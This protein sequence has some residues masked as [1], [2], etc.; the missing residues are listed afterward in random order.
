MRAKCDVC[1]ILDKDNSIKEVFFCK[2]CN[3]NI[4]RECEP[5]W[6]RRGMAALKIKFG[7]K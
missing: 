1:A 4:C 5:N 2:E 3:A 7:S 6:L